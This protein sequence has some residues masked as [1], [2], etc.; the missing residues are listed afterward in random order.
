[1]NSERQIKKSGFIDLINESVHTADDID[2]GD[3]EA[4]NKNFIVIKRG[5]VNI[6]Y[7]YIPISKVD[8]WD[9]NVLWLKIGEDEV[10]RKYEL[11][12]APDP[13]RYVV[14]DYPSYTSYPHYTNTYYP[15]LP[16]IPPRYAI[17]PRNASTVTTE[18]SNVIQCDL[19]QTRFSTEDELGSHIEKDHG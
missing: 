15:V 2:I 7:Y 11:G 6:H 10:K 1:M 5:F 12:L 8:G 17:P 9:Q 4:V 13:H 18:M 3:I 14:K 16:M 19:C